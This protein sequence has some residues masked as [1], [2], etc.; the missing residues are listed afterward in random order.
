M[1]VVVRLGAMNPVPDSDQDN[2]II[3]VSIG[4]V[5]LIYTKVLMMAYPTT[6]HVCL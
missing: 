2:L 4:K 3:T 5:N 6:N 1:L